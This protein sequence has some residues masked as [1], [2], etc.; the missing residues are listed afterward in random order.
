MTAGTVYQVSVTVS[1]TATAY[2]LQFIDVINRIIEPTGAVLVIS[3]TPLP[4]AISIGT[5]PLFVTYSLGI[6]V[7]YLPSI[8]DDSSLF[9]T[10]PLA[11]VSVQ[12]LFSQDSVNVNPAMPLPLTM[13]SAATSATAAT[14]AGQPVT[15]DV[16]P[17]VGDASEMVTAVTTP[18]HGTATINPNSTITYTPAAGFSGT[19]TFQYTAADSFGVIGTAT[20]TVTVTGQS[21]P[22]LPTSSVNVLPATEPSPTFSVSWSGTDVTG[23]GGIA[24]YNVF[25]SDNG[26]PFTAFETATTQTSATFTG[27]PGHTYGFFSVATDKAGK[28]QPTPTA[29]QAT[30]TVDSRRRRLAHQQRQ[31]P[32]RHDHDH[33]LHRELDRLSRCGRI[34][35]HLVRDL[36]LRRRRPV[37]AAPAQHHRNLL[38]FTGEAGHTYGFYS[39]ATNN[40]GLVQPTPASAQATTTVLGSPPPPPPPPPVPPVI[41]GEKAVFTRKTNKKGKPVGKAVLTGFTIDFSAPLNRRPQRTGSITSSTPSQPRR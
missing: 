29:A 23:G 13:T 41:I 32:A 22:G 11:A 1:P 25:A 19:D 38:I 20:V 17:D 12:G 6:V 21:N 7:S 36:P 14:P 34:E 15:I 28:V 16:L 27:Q 8:L 24:T 2:D 37:H 10:T 40:L 5:N 18:G 31:S 9:G 26:G 30:T 35:H 3:A 33:D 39:V 4:Q